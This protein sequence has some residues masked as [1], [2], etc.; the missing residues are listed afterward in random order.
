[1]SPARRRRAVA[2]LRD[3]LGVSER[4]ACRVVGQHR[5]TEPYE[6]KRADDDAA[7]RA[8]LRKFSGERPRWRYR[9]AHHRLREEGWQVNRKRVQRL[10]REEGLRVPQRNADVSVANAMRLFEVF[11]ALGGSGEGAA[12]RHADMLASADGRAQVAAAIA[13]QAEHFDMLGRFVARQDVIVLGGGLSNID[14]LYDDVPWE[15]SRWVFSDRVDTRL[16]RA[17]HGDSSGVRGA[18]WLWPETE[19]Q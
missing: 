17:R 2:V 5:S 4:W 8:E 15:W 10:W 12:P 6:P 19:L 14:S 3:R 7:L 16:A 9:R 18:A 11:T 13:N 1:M